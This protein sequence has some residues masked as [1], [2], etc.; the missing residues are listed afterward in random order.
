MKIIII[1]L[2]LLF[3]YSAESVA[4]TNDSIPPIPKKE[5]VKSDSSYFWYRAFYSPKYIVYN[6][7]YKNDIISKLGVGVYK[8]EHATGRLFYYYGI[9]AGYN[10]DYVMPEVDTYLGINY[11][12]SLRIRTHIGHDFDKF[13]FSYTP[14]FGLG[15][16]RGFAMIGYRI[17]VVNPN[18][19]KNE[20]QFHIS[21]AIPFEWYN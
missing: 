13:N 20:I 18:E 9:G 21:F 10:I 12:L 1:S 7:F 4:Q 14:E 11:Y 16:D 6:D 15:L 19:I 2:A 8:I 5:E 17:W 3:A